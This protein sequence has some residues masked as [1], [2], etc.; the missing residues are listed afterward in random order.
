MNQS[1]ICLIFGLFLV[2]CFVFTGCDNGSTGGSSGGGNSG[3]KGT[4]IMQNSPTGGIVYVCDSATP[5]T[6]MELSQAIGKCI[7]NSTSITG[8]RFTYQLYYSMT[9]EAF[10][11]TGSYLVI[12]MSG[13]TGSPSSIYF[14]GNVSF[15]N[16]SATVDFNSMT[17]WDSLPGNPLAY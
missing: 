5:T 14:K 17:S 4:L 9:S 8:D 6:Y 3:S 11:G 10:S 7:A 1:K 12:F 15:S 2:F 16:G 13:M